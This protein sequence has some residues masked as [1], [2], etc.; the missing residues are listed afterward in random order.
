MIWSQ[1]SASLDMLG[2][3]IEECPPKV[4][5]E[6]IGFQEFWYLAYHTL[7][8]VD[9]YMSE[10]EEGF[11]PLEP[12]TLGEL[13]PKGVL[14]DRIYTKGELFTYLKYCRKKA[15][16]R[17]NGLT[18]STAFVR[19]RFEKPAVTVAELML[20]Q[21]RHIQHHTAQLNLIL[22]QKTDVVPGWVSKGKS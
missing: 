11:E 22:R 8:F 21:M 15:K 1:F 19:C 4:W 9:Y 3:A 2:N 18:E 10:K 17:I 12:Y 6:K 7:F 16:E 14:P 5:G 20:N 13:D